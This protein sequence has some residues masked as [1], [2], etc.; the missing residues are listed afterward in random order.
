MNFKRLMIILITLVVF[1]FYLDFNSEKMR[2]SEL[3]IGDT[4][5][6]VEIADTLITR[7][8]GLSGR[9]GLLP[10]TGMFFV[11][12]TDDVYGIWMKDMNFGLDILWFDENLK[13]VHIEENVSPETYPKVFYSAT[14]ALYVL[15]VNQGFVKEHKINI[16][17]DVVLIKKQP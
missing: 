16:G 5:V 1:L 15:E 13:I 12:D 3:K 10:G 8:Q 6:Q 9:T 14:P 11:F 7:T 2:F 4:T 17:D